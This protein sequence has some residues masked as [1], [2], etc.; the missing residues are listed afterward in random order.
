M[1][2]EINYLDLFNINHYLRDKNRITLK[3]KEAHIYNNLTT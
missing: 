2:F 3:T 1:N